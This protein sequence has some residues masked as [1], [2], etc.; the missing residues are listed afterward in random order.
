MANPY[1]VWI[2]I[3]GSEPIGAPSSLDADH[4]GHPLPEKTLPVGKLR[5]EVVSP[6][7]H[8]LRQPSSQP[9]SLPQVLLGFGWQAKP[10]SAPSPILVLTVSS[11]EPAKPPSG[12]LECWVVG[13]VFRGSLRPGPSACLTSQ[14]LLGSEHWM[15]Q[16]K[17]GV[18]QARTGLRAHGRA[19]G[20]N[21]G[22][23][24]RPAAWPEIPLLS[25]HPDALIFPLFCSQSSF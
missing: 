21:G 19:F 7:P 25:H 14:A 10:G 12:F 22:A 15:N 5:H 3:Q 1:P 4:I 24:G 16:R 17:K 8:P 18:S 9:P 11:S 2:D 23:A 6:S 20:P 13:L